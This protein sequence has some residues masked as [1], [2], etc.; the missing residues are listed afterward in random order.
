MSVHL[1][2]RTASRPF[3][4]ETTHTVNRSVIGAGRATV[5]T[6]CRGDGRPGGSVHS[7]TQGKQLWRI[8]IDELAT[9][10]FVARSF[11]SMHHY[12]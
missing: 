8:L 9:L 5:A 3:N 10:A 2:F 11:V 6:S 4:R 12:L 1:F 7:I